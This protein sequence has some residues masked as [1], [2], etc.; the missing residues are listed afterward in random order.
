MLG[1]LIAGQE[2]SNALA[3]IH[4]GRGCNCGLLP[5]LKKGGR[6]TQKVR[7]GRALLRIQLGFGGCVR[8]RTMHCVLDRLDTRGE[9]EFRW[10]DGMCENQ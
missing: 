9:N 7:F 1:L 5:L 3:K 2:R 8:A 10:T 4:L 6:Q